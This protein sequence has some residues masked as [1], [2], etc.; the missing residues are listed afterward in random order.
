MVADPSMR[1]PLV[2]QFL[3]ILRTRTP[4]ILAR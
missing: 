2:S 1:I 4:L 3:N